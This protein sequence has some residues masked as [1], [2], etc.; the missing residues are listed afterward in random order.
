MEPD[1]GSKLEL[2][3]FTGLLIRNIWPLYGLMRVSQV[4]TSV[5]LSYLHEMGCGCIHHRGFGDLSES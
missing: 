5:A 4:G 2:L 1:S 3:D